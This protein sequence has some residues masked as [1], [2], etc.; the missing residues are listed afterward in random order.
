MYATAT[1][2]LFTTSTPSI[3][4]GGSSVIRTEHGTFRMTVFCDLDGR[5]HMA[6]VK[7]DVR[8]EA[9]LCRVHSEC[10]TGEVFGSRR[11]ECGPQLHLALKRVEEAGRGVVIYLRQ[12]GRGIGL[13]NKLRAYA[14]QD[15]GADTL[16]ANIALGFAG[17]LRRY[18]VAATMLKKLG[19][20]SV[21][22][23]SNNPQ[24][25]RDLEQNGIRVDRRETHHVGVN[26]DNVRYMETKKSR[27]GHVF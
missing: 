4:E 11:C 24:K 12:E 8:G 13:S 1:K 3:T 20:T 2:A 14:L 15:Q 17:D 9:V 26:E 16:E 18:D 27:M 5:E 19:V 22:L 10:L 6:V 23:M 7:G 21:V 25:M